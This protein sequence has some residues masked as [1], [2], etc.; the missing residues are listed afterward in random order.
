MRSGGR[1]LSVGRLSVS[2]DGKSIV[3][4]AEAGDADI[5]ILDGFKP[6]RTLWERLWSRKY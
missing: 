1:P 2:H 5:W 4:T 6:P 3:F